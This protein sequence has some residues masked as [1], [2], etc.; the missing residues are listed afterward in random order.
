MTLHT[1]SLVRGGSGP[2]S[3]LTS[4]ASLSLLVCTES[5][6]RALGVGLQAAEKRY[7]E[8]MEISVL[9]DEP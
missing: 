9:G 8:E 5:G 4:V 1:S 7:L 6:E 2:C 3:L